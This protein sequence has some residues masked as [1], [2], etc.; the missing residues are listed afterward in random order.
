MKTG[1]EQLND[2]APRAIRNAPVTPE[3]DAAEKPLECVK[4]LA[5]PVSNLK[6]P[7]T[8][9]QPS[10]NDIVGPLED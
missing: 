3:T 4:E 7:Q 8:A 6:Q 10:K 5:R 1:L 2:G 9:P